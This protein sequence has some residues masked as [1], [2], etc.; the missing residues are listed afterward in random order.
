MNT[1]KLERLP[2]S[3][4]ILSKSISSINSNSF[5]TSWR[6]FVGRL[7]LLCRWLNTPFG[8]NA[9]SQL[10]HINTFN[11]NSSHIH[12]PRPAWNR[13]EEH[14]TPV[15]DGRSRQSACSRSSRSVMSSHDAWG[16]TEWC[17]T[18]FSSP[19]DALFSRCWNVGVWKPSQLAILRI[20]YVSAVRSQTATGLQEWIPHSLWK[21]YE[22][23]Q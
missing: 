2:K 4:S 9:H 22:D 17:Q 14:K 16:P 6:R 13:H 12:H 21:E 7:S 5:S 3:S 10:M 15:T 1:F 8:S 23:Q 11:P 20:C 19:L 18:L